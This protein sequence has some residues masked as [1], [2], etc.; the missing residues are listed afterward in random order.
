MCPI[1]IKLWK[2]LLNI[3]I[4]GNALLH[5]F[6]L[7][8]EL[9]C[10]NKAAKRVKKNLNKKS[11]WIKWIV[12]N[13]HIK[14]F[15]QKKRIS[16]IWNEIFFPSSPSYRK[17]YLI[18]I[19]TYWNRS[20]ITTHQRIMSFGFIFFFPLFFFFLFSTSSA[21]NILRG[22]YQFST[23]RNS[24]LMQNVENFAIIMLL[25]CEKICGLQTKIK[26]KGSKYFT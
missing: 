26:V 19:H 16:W 23:L 6:K 3:S 24:V 10:I 1:K 9:M 5:A 20:A 17:C 4:M 11:I 15:N 25:H 2:F 12:V 18:C 8:N 7:F 13:M 14:I 22:W 21:E